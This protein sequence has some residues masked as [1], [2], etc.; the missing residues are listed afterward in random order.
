MDD[1][2]HIPPLVAYLATVLEYRRARGRRH[3][4]LPLLLLI[5]VAMLCG[6][7]GQSGIAAWGRDCGQRWLRQLG[8]TRRG[9][10]SQT[11]LHRLFAGLPHPGLAT[12]ER[13]RRRSRA[14]R[15]AASGRRP[16]TLPDASSRPAK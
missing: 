7:R 12:V 9:G 11:T 2:T 4:M 16:G 3:G 13:Q 14:R 15:A 10:P 8:F 6:A 1:S 5:C